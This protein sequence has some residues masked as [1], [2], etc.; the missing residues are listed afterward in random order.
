MT[1]TA[2]LFRTAALLVLPAALSAAEVTVSDRAALVAAL[3]SAGP[4]TTIRVAPGTYQGGISAANLRGTEGSPIVITAADPK[5]P[6]LFQG[7]TSGIQLSG[8]SN[9]ELRDLHFI[10]ATGNGINIDDAGNRESP[11]QGITLRRLTVKNVGPKGNRDGIKM[12]G[13]NGFTIEGCH[14]ER[15]GDAGSAIDFVGC[16]GG[17]VEQCSFT[18]E[19]GPASASANGVQTKGGSRDVVIRRCRFI[20]AGG[21][22]VNAGGSTGMQYMR[23]AS[24]GH[25]AKN[26]TVEDCYFTGSGAAV[27]FVGVDGATFQHNTLYRPTRWVLRILQETT[28][29]AFTPCRNGVFRDNLIVF[30]STDLATAANVGGGTEPGTFQFERNAWYCVD[31]PARTQS[32]I[33]LPTPEKDGVYGIDPKLKAPESGDLTSTANTPQGVR[34]PR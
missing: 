31:A 20:H 32:L 22:A 16:H 26:I 25:E 13:V 33:K 12:S 30:H 19:A 23:P 2:L 17:V 5:Q 14:I 27:A 34:T 3:E 4:G 28:D 15:W 8:C 7:G 18:H 24:P 10:G 6:P 1:L 9:V 11:A 21:R 29:A